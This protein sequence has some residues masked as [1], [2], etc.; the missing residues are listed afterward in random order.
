M[1]V[2]L[3]DTMAWAT[4]LATSE[5]ALSLPFRSTA[6][7]ETPYWA[8]VVSPVSLKLTVV[9]GAGLDVGDGTWKKVGPGQ[10]AVATP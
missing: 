5:Q 8:P 7:T 4:P 9:S 10:G 6:L 2:G 1:L 3:T